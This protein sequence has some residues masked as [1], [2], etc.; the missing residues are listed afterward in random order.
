MKN[1]EKF[2]KHLKKYV[3]NKY[4][5]AH[6]MYDDF[7]NDIFDNNGDVKPVVLEPKD[8]NDI[9]I[10]IYFNIADNAFNDIETVK[11][12]KV[13]RDYISEIENFK[14]NKEK[15]IVKTDT[16]KLIIAKYCN[17]TRYRNCSESLKKQAVKYLTELDKKGYDYAT[18]TLSYIYY[19]GDGIVKQDFKKSEKYLLKYYK[20]KGD[21]D[22]ANTLGYIYYYGRVSNGKPQYDKAYKYFTI[23]AMGG[24]SESIYKMSDMY[25]H[26][27]G[28]DKNEELAYGIVW[29][30]YK[31]EFEKLHNDTGFNNFA[32]TAL[33]MARFYRKGICRYKDEHV[34]Y[35]Y[36]L[37]ARTAII[38]RIKHYKEYGDETVLS[39]INSEISELNKK[40][41]KNKIPSSLKSKYLH[42]V[43]PEFL[44]Y[45]IGQSF[46]FKILITKE[47]DKIYKFTIKRINLYEKE[48]SRRLITIPEIALSKFTDELTFYLT[49]VSKLQKKHINKEFSI[50]D[51]DD[52]SDG[53]IT[54]TINSK[55]FIYIK[56]GYIVLKNNENRNISKYKNDK[57]VGVEFAIGGKVY[58]YLCKDKKVK[59]GDLLF[60]DTNSGKQKV[61]VK[62]VKKISKDNLF[63][64]LDDYKYAYN[65]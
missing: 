36:L 40:I 41:F 17:Q 57:I 10:N 48:L 30:R 6:E 18:Y 32:D 16:M 45:S 49:N 58:E 9:I 55:K 51:I 23:G 26:G 14:K 34:A 12:K 8:E 54:L 56:Y 37:K 35:D 29:E 11:Y 24:N 59:I 20:K 3:K 4:A 50:I 19:L 7:Y 61:K 43:F 38:E 62:Y 31:I 21:S 53:C 22:I 60:V 5:N 47:K 63:M 15:A 44:S 42:G 64:P 28:T 2:L 27:Y 13:L 1:C 39:N 65:D 33:R 46:R 52:D 25:L